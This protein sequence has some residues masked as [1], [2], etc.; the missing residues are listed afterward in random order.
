MKM[1]TLRR[2]RAQASTSAPRMMRRPTG[3]TFDVSDADD[4]FGP[5]PEVVFD[6]ITGPFGS[7]I[8]D[9]ERTLGGSRAEWRGG[10]MDEE[11]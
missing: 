11:T 4:D 1:K 5:P 6:R 2:L 9:P 8:S 10:A 3:G 7:R